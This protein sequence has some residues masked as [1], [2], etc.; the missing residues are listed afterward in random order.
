MPRMG[1]EVEAKFKVAALA[2]ARRAVRSAGGRHVGTVL[3]TDTYFDTPAGALRK[4]D[5]GLRI[6]RLRRLGGRAPAGDL[7]PL[8]TFKGPR[9]PGR[10]VKARTEVQT[11]L[12]DPD[13]LA[14]ALRACGLRETLT[15]EKRRASYRLGRCRVELD[16]LPLI[17]CFVEIEAPSAADVA[18][19]RRA[20]HLRC[21]PITEPY[22]E[23][24]A[25][26]CRRVGRSC[27]LVTFERCAR[28]AS[29]A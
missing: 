17:G 13:A 2:A 11:R 14:E 21:E 7:R 29:G 16:E 20:L 26:R 27:R 8:L 4:G 6:R 24:L 25:R 10:R 19:V 15:I 22:V 18:R 23:L 5:R 28:C 3:E 1:R 12:D 9:A